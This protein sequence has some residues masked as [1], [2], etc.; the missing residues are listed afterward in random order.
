[1]IAVAIRSARHRVQFAVEN[2]PTQKRQDDVHRVEMLARSL[3]GNADVL[4]QTCSRRHAR[5]WTAAQNALV[6]R[7]LA[8]A[9]I[10][11]SQTPCSASRR[12]TYATSPRTIAP[13][14]SSNDPSSSF[15]R[16]S[17]PASRRAATR[18]LQDQFILRSEMM[19]DRTRRRSRAR[20]IS[21]VVSS[22]SRLRTGSG[23]RPRSIARASRRAPFV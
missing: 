3:R 11:I 16:S 12:R 7:L 6:E 13:Q 15:S 2:E 23:S 21:C 17:A 19:L 18:A 22:S 9:A 5:Y 14:R 1:M 10:A 20:H 8:A 4:R